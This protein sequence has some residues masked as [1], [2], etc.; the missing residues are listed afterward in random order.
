PN[1]LISRNDD[2][3]IS[4][5]GQITTSAIST[6]A[7]PTQARGSRARNLLMEHL[8][9]TVRPARAGAGRTRIPCGSAVR[10]LGGLLQL[11]EDRGRVVLDG[12]ADGLLDRRVHRGPVVVLER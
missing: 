11:A 8:S 6:M 10:R 1:R 12:A 7:G 2:L 5:T 4:I 3:I 9:R